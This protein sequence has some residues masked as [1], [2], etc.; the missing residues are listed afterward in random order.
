MD[1]QKVGQ[2]VEIAY[3]GLRSIGALKVDSSADAHDRYKAAMGIIVEA[4][5]EGA[6]AVQKV[7]E[8]QKALDEALAKIAA[9]AEPKAPEAPAGH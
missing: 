6:A 9:P 1:T 3:S 7:A 2:A 4:I 5:N 8:L